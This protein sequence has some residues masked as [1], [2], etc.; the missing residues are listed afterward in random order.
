MMARM[1]TPIRG[2]P[3]PLEGSKGMKG[4]PES[5]V[6]YACGR[7]QN[8]PLDRAM[9]IDVLW[10]M[11]G[12]EAATELLDAT[13]A[14][15]YREADGATAYVDP[16]VALKVVGWIH[17]RT[18]EGARGRIA[19]ACRDIETA[20][21]GLDARAREYENSFDLMQNACDAAGVYKVEAM[22]AAG[23]A[24]AERRM[25]GRAIPDLG[26]V[27]RKMNAFRLDA[28]AAYSPFA[29][30]VTGA[31]TP[32]LLK[33]QVY[34]SLAKVVRHEAGRALSE[35]PEKSETCEQVREIAGEVLGNRAYLE[36]DWAG[37]EPLGSPEV[38]YDE[39]KDW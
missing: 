1:D 30:A 22:L 19:R 15:G 8:T 35:S 33:L 10:E 25:R 32:R 21:E 7:S 29:S 18:R 13:A 27:P 3:R 37:E 24:E 23:L 31:L 11:V 36:G 17:G 34:R 39:I 12:L 28:D 14:R 20:L 26:E 4:L 6:I 2:K 5:A 9:P 38:S 16:R